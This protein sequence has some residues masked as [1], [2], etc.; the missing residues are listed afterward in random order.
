MDVHETQQEE[1]PATDPAQQEA[2]QIHEESGMH[3][4]YTQDPGAHEAYMQQ[5]DAEQQPY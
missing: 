3:G 4:E 5:E 2:A 1:Q